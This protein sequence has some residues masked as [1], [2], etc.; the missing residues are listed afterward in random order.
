MCTAREKV[1]YRRVLAEILM[2]LF[3]LGGGHLPNKKV[4][5]LLANLSKFHPS[6]FVRAVHSRH[7][8]QFA[9]P[10]CAQLT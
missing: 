2:Y 4:G 6:L 1:F 7:L 5:Y 8:G 10:Y 9:I 3:T